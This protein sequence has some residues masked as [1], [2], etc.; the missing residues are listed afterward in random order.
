MVFS[1]RWQHG[2]ENRE[3]TRD[4]A[5]S[6]R[7]FIETDKESFQNKEEKCLRS[8]SIESVERRETRR[9]SIKKTLNFLNKI[10]PKDPLTQSHLRISHIQ[11]PN[12]YPFLF[13]MFTG[14]T[15]QEIC[16][17]L[18]WALQLNICTLHN[19]QMKWILHFSEYQWNSF[20]FS[21][22]LRSL[23]FTIF[24]NYVFVFLHF[25]LLSQ[26]WALLNQTSQCPSNINIHNQQK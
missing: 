20:L 4:F 8:Q 17:Y 9:T 2:F 24:W 6:K 23:S 10:S 16:V 13:K 15:Q 14:E 3:D 21:S 11:Y 5:E 12:P 25:C 1:I 18:I 26:F 22:Y 19:H 7:E